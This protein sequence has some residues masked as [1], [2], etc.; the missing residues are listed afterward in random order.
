MTYGHFLWGM[1]VSVRGVQLSLTKQK[2]AAILS[3]SAASSRACVCGSLAR[4]RRPDTARHRAVPAAFWSA[5]DICADDVAGPWTENDHPGRPFLRRAACR[6]GGPTAARQSIVRQSKRTDGGGMM[7][8]KHRR[9]AKL[10]SLSPG[11][12]SRSVLTTFRLA[13]N[14]GVV[15]HYSR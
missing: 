2:W 13:Y 3:L 5:R 14:I 9:Q 11:L 12:S 10:C 8:V 15:Y 4:V 6:V 7:S 1:N